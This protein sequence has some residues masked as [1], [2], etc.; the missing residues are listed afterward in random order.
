MVIVSNVFHHRER[1]ADYFP[2]RLRNTSCR[3]LARVLFLGAKYAACYHFR[4]LDKDFKEL[5][6]LVAAGEND[7][8]IPEKRPGISKKSSRIFDAAYIPLELCKK[9]GNYCCY[10]L[11]EQPLKIHYSL[12][13]T[14]TVKI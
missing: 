14:W 6:Q 1:Q 4:L 5:H 7:K 3:V 11:L 10:K 13:F 2:Q 9:F 12:A 8:R